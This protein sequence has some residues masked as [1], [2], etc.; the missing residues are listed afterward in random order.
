M[1]QQG[2][3][4]PGYR[5][6]G[7]GVTRSSCNASL[8]WGVQPLTGH[9]GC[10]LVIRCS[11]LG[12]EPGLLLKDH[13]GRTTLWLPPWQ[14][15]SISS[16][17]PSCVWWGED[18]VEWWISEAG[19]WN[20]GGGGLLEAARNRNPYR[21]VEARAELDGNVVGLAHTSATRETAMPRGSGGRRPA[22]GT[23]LVP[24]PGVPDPS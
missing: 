19:R 17:S 11:V 3:F 20:G 12:P 15:H 2:Q 1:G 13:P 9:K 8:A 14:L 4:H 21:F 23:K 24:A 16:A 22:V 18:G 5:V 10:L 7:V 6:A